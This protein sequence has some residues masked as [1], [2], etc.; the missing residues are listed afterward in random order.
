VGKKV[1]EE[2]GIGG[3]LLLGLLGGIILGGLLAIAAIPGAVLWFFLHPVTFWQKLG[4]L[5][6]SLIAFIV[7]LGLELLAFKKWTG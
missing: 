3:L 4:W 7:V 6:V 5:I 2:I 1:S